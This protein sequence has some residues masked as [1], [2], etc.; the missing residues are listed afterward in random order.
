MRYEIGTAYA[1]TKLRLPLREYTTPNMYTRQHDLVS[2]TVSLYFNFMTAQDQFTVIYFCFA[3]IE[4][5]EI[6]LY[7]CFKR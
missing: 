3:R 1:N 6:C 7:T 5:Y 2:L 4:L